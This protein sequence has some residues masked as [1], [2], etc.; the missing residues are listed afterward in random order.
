MKIR[1]RP[2][3]G[4]DINEAS[5]RRRGYNMIRRLEKQGFDI[6]ETFDLNEP[7]DVFV[8]QRHGTAQEALTLQE[9]GTVVIF[10]INDCHW[11]VTYHNPEEI[12]LSSVVDYIV[13]GNR[14]MCKRYA[15]VNPNAVMIQEGIEDEFFATKV[16][17]P[18]AP[19]FI[20]SW[21]GTTDNLQYIDPIAP[22]LERVA[23]KFPILVRFVMPATP[24][25]VRHVANYNFPAELIQWELDTFIPTIANAHIGI[26]PLPDTEFCRNKGYHKAIGYM[27]LGRPCVAAD[28][29]PYQ[30]I[31]EQGKNGFLALTPDEWEEALTKLL[32][33]E[34]LRDKIVRNAMPVAK[35]F[36]FDY[37]ANL[38]AKFLR[39]VEKRRQQ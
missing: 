29:A 37:V 31:I 24:K 18:P 34:K 33:S 1:W 32:D 26:A 28:I 21:H 5:W 9:R 4:G 30:E 13:T 25:N 23:Q 3:F 39:I 11:F 6:K 7:C 22:A 17:V 8:L 19:P 10:D 38:W 20:I 27:A 16:E 14:Y 15:T 12:K 35:C 36:T 2:A